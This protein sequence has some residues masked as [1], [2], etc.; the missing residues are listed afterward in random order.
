[1]VLSCLKVDNLSFLQNSALVC[2]N[3]YIPLITENYSQVADGSTKLTSNKLYWIE[4][5]LADISNLFYML[6][7]W[8]WR[9]EPSAT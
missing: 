8:R 7:S 2:V 9:V 4:D 1:M 6:A 3:W 5:Q